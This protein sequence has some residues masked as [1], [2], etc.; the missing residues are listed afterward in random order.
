[1]RHCWCQMMPI[2]PSAR[3]DSSPRQCLGRPGRQASSFRKNFHQLPTIVRADNNPGLTQTKSPS[4]LYSMKTSTA[5]LRQ[6][7][8]TACQIRPAPSQYRD[9][10][11]SCDQMRERCCNLQSNSFSRRHLLE[12][13]RCMR[14]H[15]Y[16]HLAPGAATPDSCTCHCSQHAR[17]SAPRWYSP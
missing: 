12:T 11:R 2:G 16:C 17:R 15:K 7:F 8:R 13:D 3:C 5:E 6:T 4:R 9:S 14:F 1:M 10:N